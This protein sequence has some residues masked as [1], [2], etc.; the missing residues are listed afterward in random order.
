[1]PSGIGD[2]TPEWLGEV[3]GRCVTDVRAE[4]IA[5]DSGFS[6]WLYR[7]YLSG[8]GVPGSVIVK[9]PA[10]GAAGDAMKMLGGYAREVAFYR[11]VADR[12]PLG[13]P[14]V[15][16]AEMDDDQADFVLVLEDL[17]QWDNADHL[18]GLSMEQARHCIA[19]LA[20]LH[21]WSVDAAE[22]AALE[23]FPSIDS[24]MTRDLLPAAFAPAWQ[25]YQDRA[26]A[27]IPPAVARFADRFAELAPAAIDALSERAMLI[28][29]DIRADNLFFCGGDMKVVDFQLTSKGAGATDVGY[30]VSQGLPTEARSGHDEALLREYLELLVSHG[31]T[32]YS[33]DEA[34]RHYRFAAAYFMALPLMPLLGWDSMP[35]RPRRLCMRLVERAVATIEET[36][37]VEVFR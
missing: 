19:D 21:A 5:L 18:A 25:V 34:W 8:D 31:V 3:F 13:T 26:T 10:E 22:P 23:A 12:A 20:G 1:V 11:D 30:L 2:V 27:P 32:D 7:A 33:F 9:L 35:E 36:N 17:A 29:G 24:P 6:S 4:Q 15:Y 14:Q 16:V 37:A 28:H